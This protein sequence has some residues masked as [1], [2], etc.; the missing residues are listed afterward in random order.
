MHVHDCMCMTLWYPLYMYSGKVLF[1]KGSTDYK[2]ISSVLPF[3]CEGSLNWII[4][5][6]CEASGLWSCQTKSQLACLNLVK[7]HDLYINVMYINYYAI[8]IVT[9]ILHKF[10]PLLKLCIWIPQCRAHARFLKIFL[11]V[12]HCIYSLRI[13]T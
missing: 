10:F 4:F 8:I 11:C 12:L 13:W 9:V 6:F 5:L 3:V 1:K 2:Y 7:L